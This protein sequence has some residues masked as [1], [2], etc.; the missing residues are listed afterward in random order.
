MGL[1]S[2]LL[3]TACSILYSEILINLSFFFC[4]G[5]L[6]LFFILATFV[7]DFFNLGPAGML[8]FLLFLEVSLLSLLLSTELLIFFLLPILSPL[9]VFWTFL[10]AIFLPGKFLSLIVEL[11]FFLSIT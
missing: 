9:K 11:L 8:L 5:L 7:T 10:F 6:S 1:F 4:E 2:S 3:F